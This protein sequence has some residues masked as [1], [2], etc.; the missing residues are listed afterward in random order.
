M[1]ITQRSADPPPSSESQV[2]V[3]QSRQSAANSTGC[4]SAESLMKTAAGIPACS[5]ELATYAQSNLSILVLHSNVMAMS[6][7]FRHEMSR[8]CGVRSEDK[9]AACRAS[10]ALKLLPQ[11]TAG[12]KWD[13]RSEIN[14]RLLCS[15]FSDD[16]R[17]LFSSA[18]RGPHILPNGRFAARFGAL[19]AK[20][21]AWM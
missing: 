4:A 16:S 8:F 6:N 20:G 18:W 1:V 7:S 21:F 10:A 14:G 9:A 15:S 3:C 13:H 2:I 5:L 11:H 12:R 19:S 17:W